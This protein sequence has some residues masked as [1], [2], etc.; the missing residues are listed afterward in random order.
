MSMNLRGLLLVVFFLAG[1]AVVT[2]AQSGAAIHPPAAQGDREM[3]G[4]NSAA[5]EMR[6]RAMVRHE[7]NSHKEM[8]E[9]AEEVEQI[10]AS[11]RAAFTQNQAL[12]RDELKKL[13]RMEKLARKIRG[14]AGGSDDEEKLKDPPA[15]LDA[16]VTRLAEVSEKLHKSVQKTTRLVVSASVIESANELLELIQ[17]IRTFSQ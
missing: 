6:Y 2:N 7:E 15:K 12:G 10:G 1:L 3:Q 17:H 5:E 9:R 8:V 4:P 16:A 13:E 11:L 14:N